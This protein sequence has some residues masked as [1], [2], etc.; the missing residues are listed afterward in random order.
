MDTPAKPP[1]PLP[2]IYVDRNR[3]TYLMFRDNEKTRQYVS[4]VNGQIEI[5]QMTRREWKELIRYKDCTPEHFAAVYLKSTQDISRQAR[6][7]LKGI[8]G[9][10]EEKLAPEGGPRF[11]EGSISLQQLCEVYNWNPSKVRKQLRK[12]MNKPGGRWNFTPDEAEKIISMVKECLRQ[13]TTSD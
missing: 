8:L 13:E 5:I 6:A 4:M 12:L 3:H 11:S 9:H 10:P 2:R 1:L 7:I